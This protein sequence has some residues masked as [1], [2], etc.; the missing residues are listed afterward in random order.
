MTNNLAKILIIPSLILVF[1][2]NAA[3]QSTS[4]LANQISISADRQEGQLKENVGIFEKNVEIIHGNRRITADRLE[5]HKRDELGDNKQ[6]LIATGSPAYF[7]EKQA[8]GTVMSAS[9][10]EV[11]YDVA[12]RFLTL[13]GDANISQAG[14]KIT[15]KSITYDIEQQL[16]SA[17][18]D[19]NSTDRVHTILVPIDAKKEQ[20]LNK[21][22][23]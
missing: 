10:N 3:E 1:N 21:G 23:P 16:I 15:A 14:Q 4:P 8:D 6:L 19:E 12:K 17:E 20:K 5:V 2:S 7:E 13:V 22:Q 9:A 11:R 18:K